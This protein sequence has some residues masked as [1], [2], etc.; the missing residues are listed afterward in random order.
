MP[1]AAAIVAVAALWPGTAAGQLPARTLEREGAALAL[2]AAWQWNAEKGISVA[3]ALPGSG[4]VER[5]TA[6]LR[7]H[8]ATF[9][10]RRLEAMRA[11]AKETKLEVKG[12]ETFA[13]SPAL[14]VTATEERKEGGR[15]RRRHHLFRRHGHLFEWIESIPESADAKLRG[16]VSTLRGALRFGEPA[17]AAVPEWE[18][19]FVRQKV[20]CKLPVEW[21]WSQGQPGAKVEV[22]QEDMSHVTLFRIQSEVLR[23]DG[24]ALIAVTL[25][26]HWCEEPIALCVR[27][28][29]GNNTASVFE[30]KDVRLRGGQ[31]IGGLETHVVSYSGFTKDPEG[32]KTG[33]R[34]SWALHAFRHGNNTLV[35]NEVC[36]E[37]DRARAEALFARARAGLDPYR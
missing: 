20:R 16:P 26:C 17:E 25:S 2:P 35:W 32:K 3:S 10:T 9:V 4:E 28:M 13:G 15:I 11:A 30:A 5:A 6:E 7:F 8:P 21:L 31:R 36:E 34:L 37:R 23:P 27:R 18:R 24:A 22:I 29:Q 33:E 1:T 19:D 12:G 14:V